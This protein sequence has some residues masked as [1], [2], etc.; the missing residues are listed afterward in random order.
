MRVETELDKNMPDLSDV[1]SYWEMIQESKDQ[2]RNLE[3]EFGTSIELCH[4][5][6]ADLRQ[7]IE[8][9]SES[10]NK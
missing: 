2:T 6:I 10:L 1:R 3:H 8:L 5:T 4:K 9:Q 7:T